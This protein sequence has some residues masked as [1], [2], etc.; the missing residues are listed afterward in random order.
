MSTIIDEL[1]VVLDLDPKKFTE[2]QR[3]NLDQWKKLK[4]QQ[5]KQGKDVEDAE[6]K[7]AKEDTKRS[8]EKQLRTKKTVEGLESLTKKTLGFVAVLAGA[9]ELKNFVT[10]IIK[11]DA[12]L[13]LLAHNLNVNVESLSAWEGITKRAGGE[14]GDAAG[15]FQAL[16]NAQ[17]E[18]QL[19][20]NS[21]AIPFLRR[22]GINSLDQLKDTEGTLFKISAAMQH[23]NPA[24]AQTLGRG[25][26]F[27]PGL[28]NVLEKGPAAVRAMLAEQRRLGVT[29]AASA[30][31][32][33]ALTNRLEALKAETMDLGRGLEVQAL[34][35]LNA[36]LQTLIQL[37]SDVRPAIDA[38]GDLGTA[39]HNVGDAAD[40]LAEKFGVK[41]PNA[42]GA[43]RGAIGFLTGVMQALEHSAQAVADLLS[44]KFRKAGKELA[45]A[46]VSFYQATNGAGVAQAAQAVSDVTNPNL[47][48]APRPA[49]APG[50][51]P[52][53]PTVA[54][55]GAPAP[56]APLGAG[57]EDL[58]YA[59]RTLI[60][61]GKGSRG[62]MDVAHVIM[63]RIRRTGKGAKDV[64]T[65]NNGLTWQFEP[66]GNAATRARLQAIDVN[67]KQYQDA[68]L[69]WRK[70]VAE[71]DVTNGA[72]LFLA[73]GV[74]KAKGRK[75]QGWE[76]EA[77]KTLD[78]AGQVFYTGA[79]PGDKGGRGGSVKNDIKIAQITVN[80]QATD[81]KAI[82]KDIGPAIKNNGLV[83]QANTGL[84]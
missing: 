80:T 73:P 63:N 59:V 23:M 21:A 36:A 41:I 53:T 77:N 67:S 51:Q 46:G 54:T 15:A 82:A 1:I 7:A 66:W 14:A 29:T 84:Q 71:K 8:K 16:V 65:A 3:E 76:I 6:S 33:L 43:S 19:T 13:G 79:F 42:V 60:G 81:A 27:A 11:T 48:R 26:G 50:R 61:E 18:I 24:Q 28:I 57:S 34:P 37:G 62:R 52:V 78:R 68:L 31:A 55:P 12:Q 17:Q 38:A 4:G 45:L 72:T 75:K 32:A 69:D 56:A 10:N 49:V 40:A 5:K 70:A 44:G 20:G 2:K 39:M 83:A 58:D 47:P 30:A 74:Q 25:L 22:L 9:N 64:V 35:A